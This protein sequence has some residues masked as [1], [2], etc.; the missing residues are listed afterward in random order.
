MTATKVSVIPADSEKG[1]QGQEP[2]SVVNTNPNGGS[3]GHEWIR[4][5]IRTSTSFVINKSSLAHRSLILDSQSAPFLTGLRF[6]YTLL[7]I[8]RTLFFI[9]LTDT[10]LEMMNEGHRSFVLFLNSYLSGSLIP[11]LAMGICGVLYKRCSLYWIAGILQMTACLSWY[12]KVVSEPGDHLD[13]VYFAYDLTLVVLSLWIIRE[14]WVAQQIQRLARVSR[15]MT[16]RVVR[17]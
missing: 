16:V 1:K 3:S 12:A 10:E 17:A 15:A 7:L 14:H 9:L 6:C 13:I 5:S 4:S 11:I 2:G 8:M